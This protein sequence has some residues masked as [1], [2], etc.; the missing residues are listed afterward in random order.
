MIHDRLTDY[1]VAE[2]FG[3]TLS[4]LYKDK[5]RELNDDLKEAYA[6]IDSL[7]IPQ[8]P[9]FHRYFARV[10]MP[11]WAQE[12]FI[13]IEHIQKIR[14]IYKNIKKGNINGIDA[15]LVKARNVR[16]SDIFDFSM[17]GRNVSCPFHGQDSHPSASIKFNYFVCFACGIKFD[18]I[19]FYQKLNP[20]MKFKEAVEY[21]NKL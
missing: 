5:M 12:R 7:Q 2:A 21:L 19:A 15:A 14:N 6:L 20:G 18:V 4:I 11:H 3:E 9:E 8:V 1:Q 13:A 10:S 17:R 16:I